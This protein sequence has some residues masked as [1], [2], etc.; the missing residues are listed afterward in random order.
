MDL[1]PISVNSLVAKIV[2]MKRGAYLLSDLTCVSFRVRPGN[3]EIQD[4]TCDFL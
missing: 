2:K 1:K 4:G 3:E